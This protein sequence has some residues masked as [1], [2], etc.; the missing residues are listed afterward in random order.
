MKLALTYHVEGPIDR[1]SAEIYEEIS[2]QVILADELGFDYVWFAEHHAHVHLGHMPAPLLFALHLAGRTKRIAIG[3]AVICLNMH[4]AIDVAEQVAVADILTGGRISPG[5]G[6]GSTPEE[7]NFY[8]RPDVD[9]ET[10]H[11]RFEVCLKI[12]KNAWRGR[13]PDHAGSGAAQINSILPI[14]RPDLVSRS[15]IA[16]NS[17]EAAAIAGRGGHNIMFS[18]LRSID[19]YEA[20]YDA[21]QNAGGRGSVAANRPVYIGETDAAAWAEAEPALRLLWRR[22]VAEGKIPADRPEPQSFDLTNAPGQFIVG[23][24]ETVGQSIYELQRRVPFDTFNIEPHWDGLSEEQVHASL[25]RLATPVPMTPASAHE[26]SEA[27][28]K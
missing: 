12:I 23:G 5:F 18:Y 24:T 6:S 9:A 4:D 26:K 19:E 11:A 21:Y 1:P 3:T 22:F 13:A 7:L 20:F 2:R 15:W 17:I 28:A 14:A 25:R 8:V 27:V 16:A 10:R